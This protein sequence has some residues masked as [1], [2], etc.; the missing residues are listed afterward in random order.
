MRFQ[1]I[2]EIVYCRPWLITEAGHAAIRALLDTKLAESFP[3]E[4]EDWW[5]GKPEKLPGLEIEDGVATIPIQGVIGQ[6]LSKVEKSCGACDVGDVSR[7][8]ALA[9]SRAD[10]RGILLDFDTPGGMVTGTPELADEIHAA[11]L[12]GGGSKPVFAFADSLVASA[13]YW[14][15]ASADQVFTTRTA[16]VGS[17]GVYMPWRDSSRAHENAGIKVDLIKAGR[18]KGMGY[19]GTSLTQE[20]RE[21]L[22]DQ[23]NGIYGMFTGHVQ[24]MRGA[25]DKETM[26]GQIFMAAAAQ[27]RNLID[28]I[29]KDRASVVRMLR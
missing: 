10:V 24:A 8:L 5:T 26:Q 29:V 2:L 18:Y 9:S 3:R 7:E 13:G 25:V 14:L 22:Q 20:Q 23:V 17:I 11:S 27:G 6:K 4:G 12:G 21:L 1:H 16:E 28:G 15:A 19:P